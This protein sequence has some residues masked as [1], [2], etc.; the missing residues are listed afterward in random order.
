MIMKG[1]IGWIKKDGKDEWFVIPFL[2]GMYETQDGYPDPAFLDDAKAYMK[3]PGF[4]RSFLAVK[5]SQ[6]R[7]IPVNRSLPLQH[8]VATYDQI[9]VLVQSAPGPFVV[10]NCICRESS[11]M[12]KSACSKTVRKETCLAFGDMAAMVL[13]R[14][15]GREVTKDE[16][17]SIL[18]QNEEDGLVLQPSNT[19]RL[20]F[21]CSCCGCCCGMLSF[22]KHMPHPLDFWTSNHH[23]EVTA[24][25]CSR[26]GTCVSRCQVNAAVLDGTSGPANID[27]NRCIGCGL[28]VPTCPSGAVQLKKR[29]REMVPPKD[30]E[31]LYDTI[32][33]NT[34][35]PAGQMITAVKAVLGMKQ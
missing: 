20:E 33:K 34:K 27:L 21:V 25:L 29:K 28:C 4:G 22:Q 13:R 16:V 9:R 30:A 35:R 3:T 2:I 17:V 7:T 14:N 12:R 1:A 11:A 32:K 23:A 6:M 24:N 5:P 10:L 8:Q 18:Q 31:D 26:C 19:Q 15:H